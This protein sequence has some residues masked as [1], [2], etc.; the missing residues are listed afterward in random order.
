MLLINFE[1]CI[2]RNLKMLNLAELNFCGLDDA[3][4]TAEKA[5]DYSTMFDSIVSQNWVNLATVILINAHLVVNQINFRLAHMRPFPDQKDWWPRLLKQ[6]P[7]LLSFAKS[8]INHYFRAQSLSVYVNFSFSLGIMDDR[9]GPRFLYSSRSNFQ[10]LPTS[11]LIRNDQTFNYFFDEILPNFDLNDYLENLLSLLNIKYD[12]Y[13]VPLAITFNLCRSVGIIYGKENE[14]HHKKNQPNCF[15][16]ALSSIFD[17]RRGKLYRLKKKRNR[18]SKRRGQLLK[19]A[20]L[21]FMKKNH[22]NVENPFDTMRGIKSEMIDYVEEFLKTRIFIFSV[23]TATGHKISLYKKRLEI[24]SRSGKRKIVRSLV[25]ERCSNSHYRGVVNLI[26]H[27]SHIV[28]SINVEND[29]K[30]FFCNVCGYK[31]SSKQRLQSHVCTQKLRYTCEKIFSMRPNFEKMYKNLLNT[32]LPKEFGFVYVGVKKQNLDFELKL[33]FRE[34]SCSKGGE[35]SSGG[36]G[37][38]GG[39]GGGEGGGGHVGGGGGGGGGGNPNNILSSEEEII[40][41]EYRCSFKTLKSCAEFLVKSLYSKSHEL[42]TKRLLNNYKMIENLEEKTNKNNKIQHSKNLYGRHCEL[43]EETRILDLNTLYSDYLKNITCY[44]SCSAGEM[45][46]LEDLMEEIL[47]C[48]IGD[49]GKDNVNLSYNRGKL[50]QVASSKGRIKFMTLNLFSMSL[51]SDNIMENGYQLMRSVIEAFICEFGINITT[52]KT[53]TEIGCKILTSNMSFCDRL[54]FLSPSKILYEALS[55]TVRYGILAS[56]KIVIGK[57]LK[58]QTGVLMDFER[59]YLS[60]LSDIKPWTGIGIMYKKDENGYFRCQPTRKRHCSAN[61]FLNFIQNIIPNNFELHYAGQGGY[62]LRHGSKSLCVDGVLF[63]SGKT[64]F[65]LYDGCFYHPHFVSPIDQDAENNDCHLHVSNQKQNHKDCEVCKNAEIVRNNCVKPPLFRLKKD[66]NVDSRHKL[67]KQKTY[68]EIYKEEQELYRINFGS[69]SNDLIRIRECAILRYFRRPIKDFCEKY[70]LPCKNKY[71][72]LRLG[73]ELLKSAEQAYPLMRFQGKIRTYALIDLIKMG[74]IHGFVNCSL[75]MSEKG[76]QLFGPIK[77]FSFRRS[78]DVENICEFENET[79]AT[80]LLQVL[81]IHKE[82]GLEV[83]S[84]NWFIEFSLGAKKIFGGLKSKVMGAI[85]NQKNQYFTKLLKSSINNSIGFFGIR[86]NRFPQPILF[87]EDDLFKVTQM[88]GFVNSRAISNSVQ[89]MNFKNFRT[90]VFNLAHVHCQIISF[91]RAVLLSIVLDIKTYYNLDICMVNTDSLTVISKKSVALD[92]FSD[93]KSSFILDLFLKESLS[94]E[95]L[96][97]Y[98][99]WRMTFFK[100]VTV[101]SQH[102]KEYLK[103]L[104]NKTLF[105]PDSC[106]LQSVGIHNNFKLKIEIIT[107]HG[108]LRTPTHLSFFNTVSHELIEKCSGQYDAKIGKVPDCLPENLH[109][110]L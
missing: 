96:E 104:I 62:E 23:K 103:C 31:F 67:K 17:I 105:S 58:Y 108:M 16:D 20:F 33:N 90:P 7:V 81:L 86:F 22:I 12:G 19:F 89:V 106:C 13:I 4:F 53:A 55:T 70:N 63:E 77:P 93:S 56:Q 35:S 9:T 84:L 15:F 83:L 51:I 110:L 71:K 41:G 2:C 82:L 60:I 80:N 99:E 28:A 3:V 69:E 40:E 48:L 29:I 75:K 8:A 52:L 5:N 102:K 73:D 78:K 24:H 97:K 14:N 92:C 46:I 43:L 87:Q 44:I 37:S 54:Q 18:I 30:N 68:R 98:V 59:F 47:L 76:K 61:I 10:G 11:Y 109:T 21:N 34:G 6:S 49:Y 36:G 32:E 50:S 74:K 65:I 27:G 94:V 45:C 39:G 85:D 64:R 26:A 95:L 66:E 88:H 38:G 25:A 42:L 72:D 101:C 91:G 107:D 100:D 79:V 57:G 1:F